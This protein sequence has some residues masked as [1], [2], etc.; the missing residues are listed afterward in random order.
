MDP[1]AERPRDRTGGD[2]AAQRAR[3]LAIIKAKSF[4]RGQVV[5][6]SGQVSDYYLDLKPTMFDPEGALLLADLVL[7]RLAEVEVDLIGG[8]EM[9]AV[10]LISTI[11]MRSAMRH[12]PLPG[13]FVRKSVKDHG[14][15]RRIEGT[16][17]I[18][19]KR[20]VILEDVT[21]TGE[22][23]MSAVRAAEAAEAHVTLILSVV[24]RAEGAAE[25]F[26]RSG[27]AFA[28]LFS[29]REFLAG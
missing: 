29:A 16:S 8:L 13:F 15:R 26:A 11:A 22:S 6:A 7:N 18:V 27:L 17:E 1:G 10:P 20:V 3:L 14:T 12:R 9:G 4:S 5:L 21:T 25:F 23:A 24:D 2:D 19:G 28:Q